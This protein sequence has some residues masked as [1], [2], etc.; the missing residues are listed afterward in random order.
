[1]F[2]A[3]GHEKVH[4]LDGGL[5]QWK[6]QG[7]ELESSEGEYSEYVFHKSEETIASFETIRSKLDES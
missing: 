1:M 3:F 6:A 2:K 5:A 4:V 7:G